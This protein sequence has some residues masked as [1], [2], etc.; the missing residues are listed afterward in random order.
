MST[1]WVIQ[2]NL[3]YSKFSGESRR[4]CRGNEILIQSQIQ[5]GGNF[6]RSR[7]S[8]YH[9]LPR[10]APLSNFCASGWERERESDPI[11]DWEIG[12]KKTHFTFC[13]FASFSSSSYC[14]SLGASDTPPPMC[15]RPESL[16]GGPAQLCIEFEAASFVYSKSSKH[17][18]RPLHNKK[19][20][21]ELDCWVFRQDQ[22]LQFTSTLRL[23]KS[24]SC[25]CY[26]PTWIQVWCVHLELVGIR[27]G[28]RFALLFIS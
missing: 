24:K 27:K 23:P 3:S 22:N 19:W 13:S 15:T 20:G 17:S 2:D 25:F 4:I 14:C 10:T 9:R 16:L 26:G 8:L 12:K 11:S 28:F 18:G 7:I 1:R 21:I 5:L 6:P